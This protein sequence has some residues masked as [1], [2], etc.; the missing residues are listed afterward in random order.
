MAKH[1]YLYKDY[2]VEVEVQGGGREMNTYKYTYNKTKLT[3]SVDKDL[4]KL[5]REN[6]INISAFLEEKL[7]EYLLL[8]NECGCR[9]LN[10]GYK[11]GK[12]K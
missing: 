1:T 11:L 7:R 5:A 3:L 8:N 10:P 9:D 2:Y 12:L 6:K 4:I